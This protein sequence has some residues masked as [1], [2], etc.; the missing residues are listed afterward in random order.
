MNMD[1]KVIYLDHAATTATLKIVFFILFR[2]RVFIR[3]F[4]QA[5]LRFVSKHFFT[6]GNHLLPHSSTSKKKSDSLRNEKIFC[7][8]LR[9]C[10][11]N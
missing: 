11:I 8:V 6:I 2:I 4:K 1:K 9:Y 10:A 7:L 5:T 3:F